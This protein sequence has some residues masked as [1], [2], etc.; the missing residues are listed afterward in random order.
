MNWLRIWTFFKY[1]RA[2]QAGHTNVIK[3]S[4]RTGPG[5]RL[6]H[7]ILILAE[8]KIGWYEFLFN[9]F[10]C[11]FLHAK[12]VQNPAKPH[13]VQSVRHSWKC[14]IVNAGLRFSVKLSSIEN[15]IYIGQWLQIKVNYSLKTGILSQILSS[16]CTKCLNLLLF[17]SE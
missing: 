6:S 13:H 7:I 2:S 11:R 5:A 15:S 12:R 16:S 9:I 10:I 4:L 14:S 17:T 3:E 8:I 1:F